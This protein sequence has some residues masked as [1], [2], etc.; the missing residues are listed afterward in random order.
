M[1]ATLA[2]A[3]MQTLSVK[4]LPQAP[5]AAGAGAAAPP[6]AAS[7][8]GGQAGSGTPSPRRA[9]DDEPADGAA[10]VVPFAEPVVNEEARRAAEA[11][12]MSGRGREAVQ[13]KRRESIPDRDLEEAEAE[14]QRRARAQELESIADAVS[15][16]RVNPPAQPDTRA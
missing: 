13:R 6:A 11:L 9:E 5:P 10:G 14:A 2:I 1:L 4:K 15:R 8:L 3:S 16:S 7:E 12:L